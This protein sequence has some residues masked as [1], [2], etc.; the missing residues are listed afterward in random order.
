MVYDA[1]AIFIVKLYDVWSFSAICFDANDIKF[2]YERF[3]YFFMIWRFILSEVSRWQI[4]LFRHVIECYVLL[5]YY[6]CVGLLEFSYFRNFLH[7]K[8]LENLNRL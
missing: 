4:M 3:V 2:T 1:G 7:W 8:E 6:D 5:Q